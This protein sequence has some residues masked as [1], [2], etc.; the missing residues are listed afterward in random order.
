MKLPVF[1]TKEGILCPRFG[2][3]RAKDKT[4]KEFVSIVENETTEILGDIFQPRISRPVG[5]C[6]QYAPPEPCLQRD[7]SELWGP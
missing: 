7:G 1:G 2:L 3:K 4:D 5:Y 6:R